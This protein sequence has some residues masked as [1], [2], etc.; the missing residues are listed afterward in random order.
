MNNLLEF[1]YQISQEDRS[2]GEA[3]YVLVA[4]AAKNAKE[5][6]SAKKGLIDALKEVGVDVDPDMRD[7]GSDCC[8]RT[9]DADEYNAL[10]TKIMCPNSLHA[11]AVAGWVP[12]AC[13]DMATTARAPVYRVKFLDVDVAGSDAT[14]SDVPVDM[15]KLIK[16]AQEWGSASEYSEIEKSVHEGSEAKKLREN[17]VA[18]ASKEH[19]EL[20]A[21]K[22]KGEDV[23]K[24]LKAAEDRLDTLA[25]Q[26]KDKDA[27]VNDEFSVYGE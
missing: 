20:L 13:G 11:L 23:D 27:A 21:R 1:L 18:T 19:K 10:V 6:E 12:V 22:S 4:E 26:A 9:D 17:V 7:E 5:L 15:D 25:K 14:N 3:T 2:I 24:E 8:L 16:K